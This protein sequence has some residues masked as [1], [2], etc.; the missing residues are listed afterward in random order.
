MPGFVYKCLSIAPFTPSPPRKKMTIVIC[1]SWVG[2]QTPIQ[3]S[4]AGY[5]VLL[6]DRVKRI[7]K[8]ANYAAPQVQVA[9]FED[10][11][12]ILS[13]CGRSV[14][15]HM[16]CVAN[17]PVLRHQ[18]RH[19]AIKVGVHNSVCRYGSIVQS[20]W[21]AATRAFHPAPPKRQERNRSP[22]VAI[23]VL[24]W[25]ADLLSRLYAGPSVFP[26]DGLAQDW[27][28]DGEG[29]CKDALFRKKQKYHIST[30]SRCNNR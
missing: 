22:A 28:H 14:R 6:M 30:V 18:S 19:T 27:L 10:Q 20:S 16:C 26:V 29:H 9:A 4:Q 2:Y 15:L 5:C 1:T 25:V 8:K 17:A 21:F 7:V 12:W 13:F 11:G 24:I 3:L 23:S